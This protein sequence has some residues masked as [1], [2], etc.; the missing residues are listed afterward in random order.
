MMKDDIK[1]FLE[2]SLLEEYVMGVIDP[3]QIPKVEH[4]INSYP[5]VKSAFDTLQEN[6]EMLASQVAQTPPAGTR[7]R[8]M[9]SLDDTGPIQ[10]KPSSRRW[11]GL[12]AASLALL[13]GLASLFLYQQ[14]RDLSDQVDTLEQDYNILQENCE[15]YQILYA[16][17]EANWKMLADP[18]TKV[19]A[20]SGNEK[21]SALETVAYW[22]ETDE[23]SYL[24]ILSF[25]EMSTDQCLQ[26]WADVNGEM[27]SVAILEDRGDEIISIPF[28]ANATSLNITIEPEG[29][30]EHATVENLVASV[31]I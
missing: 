2:T 15:E 30:S 25:P 23:S 22:N 5:E 1:E 29:G 13:L 3:D 8:I 12:L 10:L 21:A 9:K 6:I 27:I 20:L 11:P 16:Q 19:L 28:K 31:A 18:S 4:Y 7:E 24:R 17:R 14:N 26:L